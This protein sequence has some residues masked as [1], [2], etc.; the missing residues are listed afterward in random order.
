[1]DCKAGISDA[2]ALLEVSL[3]LMGVWIARPE[4][5]VESCMT[6]AAK[7]RATKQGTSLRRRRRQHPGVAGAMA[8]KAYKARKSM[9][10]SSLGPQP[11]SLT[12]A[13]RGSV[14]RCWARV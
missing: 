11:V 9:Q 8:P 12:H 6:V 1:M 14:H 13:G 3:R 5:A 7:R 4:K 10:I 2:D